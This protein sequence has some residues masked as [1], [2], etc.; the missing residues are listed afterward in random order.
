ML[1][2]NS[3]FKGKDMAQEN[4][5]NRPE[6]RESLGAAYPLQGQQTL[7][8][9]TADSEQRWPLY[10][11]ALGI[12]A[13]G[14]AFAVPAALNNQENILNTPPSTNVTSLQNT[15]TDSIPLDGS[16]KGPAVPE[17]LQNGQLIGEVQPV[18][19]LSQFQPNF[20]SPVAGRSNPVV[21]SSSVSAEDLQGSSNSVPTLY[22]TPIK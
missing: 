2:I 19:S 5:K 11:L 21:Q 4:E 7:S 18:Q 6:F 15:P 16:L 3:L 22:M 17:I 13:V 12:L 20:V 8:F 9:P 14:A 1:I 10:L